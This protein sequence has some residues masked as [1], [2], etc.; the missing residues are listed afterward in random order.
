MI[1]S[2]MSVCAII[3]IYVALIKGHIIKIC[4]KQIFLKDEYF[5]NVNKC[6]INQSAFVITIGTNLIPSKL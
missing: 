3:L 6:I 4:F 1:N 5:S 2:A